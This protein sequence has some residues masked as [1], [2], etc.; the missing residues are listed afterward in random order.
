MTSRSYVTVHN[1]GPWHEELEKRE[2]ELNEAKND[3]KEAKTDL[4]KKNSKLEEIYERK[5]AGQ[6]VDDDELAFA[7]QSYNTAQQSHMQASRI[8]DD[9]Y[10]AVKQLRAQL[11]A[12]SS[13]TSPI[14]DL[15]KKSPSELLQF[16]EERLD[17]QSAT[18]ALQPHER[19]VFIGRDGRMVRE[20]E[21]F[22]DRER[23]LQQAVDYIID[24]RVKQDMPGPACVVAAPGV[25]KS[26]LLDY[27]CRQTLPEKHSVLWLV[28]SYNSLTAAIDGYTMAENLVW[29]LLSSYYFSYPTSDA[30]AKRLQL[31]CAP[32]AK[33]LTASFDSLE[34]LLSALLT[35]FEVQFQQHHRNHSHTALL[36]D[37]TEKGSCDDDNPRG[38]YTTLKYFAR[39]GRRA[40]HSL[41]L[42]FFIFVFVAENLLF[43]VQPSYRC[44]KRTD[45]SGCIHWSH[46]THVRS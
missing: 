24:P 12:R 33:S 26:T 42:L 18:D 25:G 5:R 37:E 31:R 34:L 36:V 28:I 43:C 22:V 15:Q 8:F 20:P 46:S 40:L 27:L 23:V 38:L 39:A 10:D 1:A 7:Q 35:A 16:I 3:L 11:S 4:E 29:R 44:I 14:E 13:T 2:A 17:L 6:H 30:Q 19:G 32:V 41:L 21:I 45:A 9:A